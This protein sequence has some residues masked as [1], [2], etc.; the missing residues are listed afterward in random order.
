MP[1]FADDKLIYRDQNL[2]FFVHQR[3]LVCVQGYCNLL[4]GVTIE[5][6]RNSITR[7]GIVRL[8]FRVFDWQRECEILS[9]LGS[10]EECLSN[11]YRRNR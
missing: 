6:L 10:Y 2:G 5:G 4:G 9:L 1:S 3:Y 7:L 11:T 8:G